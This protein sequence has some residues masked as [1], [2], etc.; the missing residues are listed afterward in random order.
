ML[1]SENIRYC[2]KDEFKYINLDN[3]PEDFNIKEYIEL[4]KD[5]RDLNITEIE[6]YLHYDNTGYKENI[7]YKYENIPIDFNAKEYVELNEDLRNLNFTELEGKV[8]YEN[9]GY[10]ENRKYKYD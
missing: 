8:H 3:I 4:N 9:D 1:N 5:L 2:K 7:K 10:K 6:G